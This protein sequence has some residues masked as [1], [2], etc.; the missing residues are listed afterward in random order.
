M[1]VTVKAMV[2]LF[3]ARIL[4]FHTEVGIIHRH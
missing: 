3:D 4:R 2:F 1:A